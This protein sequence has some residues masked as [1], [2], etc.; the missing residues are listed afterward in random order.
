MPNKT[1]PYLSIL[2][3]IILI[4]IF[5]SIY[6]ITI[7]LA[8]V[9]FSLFVKSL[10]KHYYYILFTT[11]IAF[12]FIESIHGVDIFLFT[13]ISLVIYYF[14]IPRLRHIFSSIL[15][16][17][18]V[19]VFMFYFIFYGYYLL[20]NIFNIKVTFLFIINFIIDS[21]IVGFILWD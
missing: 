2:T 3:V 15:V 10:D 13:L 18:V 11:I 17:E 20:S 8:G 12:L 21:I 5:F 14:F 1:Y 6:F 16:R 4:N 9:V 19:Y 7:F